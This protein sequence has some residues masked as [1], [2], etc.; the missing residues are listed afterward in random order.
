M[1]DFSN[2]YDYVARTK[3]PEVSASAVHRVIVGE[4]KA[5]D[6]MINAMKE[7]SSN[8][9]SLLED[10]EDIADNAEHMIYLPLVMWY[11]DNYRW[12]SDLL[13]TIM[14]GDVNYVTLDSELRDLL[15]DFDDFVNGAYPNGSGDYLMFSNT[16]GYLNYVNDSTDSNVHPDNFV[17]DTRVGN[18]GGGNNA[19]F[20]V[21]INKINA[22][23]YKKYSGTYVAPYSS[24]SG[25]ILANSAVM[26]YGYTK[27]L[28]DTD[29]TEL[30]TLIGA[31][32]YF[33]TS[34]Q[35]TALGAYVI[36]NCLSS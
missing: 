34:A 16:A 19:L 22:I 20:Y 12:L 26:V 5:L 25:A 36:A 33:M 24:F 32:R 13:E 9:V 8:S 29:N 15:V 27:S 1:L 28:L 30:N 7:Y 17:V 14:T 11:H 35:Y 18:T 2:L 31:S 23:I 21:I 6:S 3:L 4:K 10:S